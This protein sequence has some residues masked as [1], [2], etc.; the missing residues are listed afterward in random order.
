[1]REN[2][3]NALRLGLAIIV[4]LYHIGKLTE[5]AYFSIFPGELAVKCFFVI[6]GFLISQ[7]YL[8][9]SNLKRYAKARFFRIYPLY[10]LCVMAC[11]MFGA[12]EYNRDIVTYLAFGGGK[13]LIANLSFANFVAPSLPGLFEHNPLNSA[14]NGSLWTIK[15]EVMFYL[16]V[17]IIFGFISK[18]LGFKRTVF[19]ISAASLASSI[20]MC[21][22]ITAYRLPTSIG[23]QLPSFMIYFMLGAAFPLIKKEAMKTY[24]LPV[25]II[26]LIIETTPIVDTIITPFACAGFVYIIAFNTQKIK[27]PDSIGDISYGVYIFH[28]PVI[29]ALYSYGVYE[30]RIVGVITTIVIVFL[31]SYFSWHLLE[32]KVTSKGFLAKTIFNSRTAKI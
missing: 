8:N 1:M 16:S 20:L 18:H 2:N 29:Q 22:L 23:N 14:V 5:Q 32:K 15:I 31:A 30:N 26:A 21:I 3:F 27:I 12:I 28:Y 24:L 6:S 13:Y 9:N 19:A 17:P 4:M 10:F 11:F 25:F 7:S